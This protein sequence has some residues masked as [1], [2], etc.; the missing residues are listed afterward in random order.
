L[1]VKTCQPSLPMSRLVERPM[2]RPKRWGE[3]ELARLSAMVDQ[4]SL[5]YWN[6]AQTQALLEEFR[7]HYPMEHAF[8]TSS[9]TAALHVAV[10]A[11][12]L[13]PGDEVIVPA[14]TDMGSVIGILF[15]QA[16][17]VFADLEPDTLNLDPAD[18]RRRVTARTRAIM[19]VHFFGIPCDM[20]ALQTIAREHGLA[21]VEDCAQAWGARWQGQPV[22]TIGDLAGF[23][24][25][26]FKHLSCGDGGMVVARSEEMGRDLSRWGDKDYDRV[27]G[28][29]NPIELALNYR[30]SEPQAAVAAAQMTRLTEIVSARRRAGDRLT[31]QL[32]DTPGI[33]L[34]K[35]R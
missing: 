19:P 12:R 5:F 23:S 33:R 8:P 11:L 21:L 10:A 1:R 25:N 7:R 28:R 6:G 20:G 32:E 15:Q 30:M 14:I 16:V 22:G 17:P 31:E 4:P 35:A 18:V 27:T 9:G 13:K 26:D 34:P 24:F 29:R 2:P 3:A